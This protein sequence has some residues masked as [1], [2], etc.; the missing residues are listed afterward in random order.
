MT[1]TI[2]I[3]A[4][5]ASQL[6]A[7]WDTLSRRAREALAVEAYRDDVLSA[8]DIG[9]L[10][11]HSSR[12]EP[13]AFLHEKQAYLHYTEDDFARDIEKIWKVTSP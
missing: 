11:G 2:D 1:I 7:C 13:E 12:W 3:P 8:A 10:L 9:R 6:Q 4:D 5:I